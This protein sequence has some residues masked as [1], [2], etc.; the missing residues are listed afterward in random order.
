ME[1]FTATTATTVAKIFMKSAGSSF[2]SYL[3]KA[4]LAENPDFKILVMQAKQVAVTEFQKDFKGVEIF[5]DEQFEQALDA[6]ATSAVASINNEPFNIIENLNNYFIKEALLYHENEQTKDVYCKSFC[7]KFSI[8][9]YAQLLSSKKYASLLNAKEVIAESQFRHNTTNTLEQVQKQLKELKDGQEK[10]TENMISSNRSICLS[11]SDDEESLQLSKETDNEIVELFNQIEQLIKDDGPYTEQIRLS[12]KVIIKIPPNN[13]SLYTKAVNTL[14]GAYLRGN[15]T[16]YE[17]GLNE[18][19]KY[20]QYFNTYSKVI[21]AALLNN[22]KRWT[23][24]LEI[25]SS[26]SKSDVLTF[27]RKQQNSYRVVYS[28][29]KYHLNDLRDAHES[30]E[31]CP[32]K[33]DPEYIYVSFMLSSAD[34]SLSL[35][36]KATDIFSN[37][38]S[39]IRLIHGALCY[40]I[41]RFIKLQKEYGN[42]LEAMEQLAPHLDLAF[43]RTK[44]TIERF[45][46]A[47]NDVVKDLV[48]NIPLLARLSGRS[49]D[50]IDIIQYALDLSYEE[51]IFLQNS[52]VCLLE[53]GKMELALYCMEQIRVEQMIQNDNGIEIY[54]LLLRKM[55]KSEKLTSILEEIANLQISEEK[56]WQPLLSVAMEIGGETFYKLA[57]EA[58]KKFPDEGWAILAVAESYIQQ[59]NFDK[60][61]ALLKSSLEQKGIKLFAMIRLAK[62]YASTL[63]RPEEA[64]TYY[65]EVI[66]INTPINEKIEYVHCLFDIKK[67]GDVI[68]KVDEYDPTGKVA[69]LQKLKSF[70]CYELGMIKEAKKIIYEVCKIETDDY[71]AHYNHAIFC[72]ELGMTDELIEALLNTIRIRPNDFQSHLTLSQAFLSQGKLIEA[73]KHAEFS[74][75][76][77]FKN[78]IAHFNF[79]N[80]HR[81][82]SQAL[83]EDTYINSK[84]LED[85]HR[86]ALNNYTTR[87]PKSKIMYSVQIPNDDDGKPS[88]QFIKEMLSQ[89]SEQESTIFNLYKDNAAPLSFLKTGLKMDFYELWCALLGNVDGVNLVLSRSST[90]QL[91]TDVSKIR[92]SKNILLDGMSLIVLQSSN[93]LLN[94]KHL[95]KKIL[96]C[97][98]TAKEFMA[99]KLRLQST[100]DGYMSVGMQEGKMVREDITSDKISHAI[101][102]IDN[103]SKFINE[104]CEVIS[105]PEKNKTNRKPDQVSKLLD[106]EYKELWNLSSSLEACSS[107]WADGNIIELARTQ[108]KE[109]STIQ[110]LIVYLLQ[111]KIITYEQYA[112]YIGDMIIAN[113]Q[114]ITFTSSESTIFLLNNQSVRGEFYFSKIIKG[115]YF[116]NFE[117]RLQFISDIIINALKNNFKPAWLVTLI[118]NDLLGANVDE[119]HKIFFGVILYSIAIEQNINSKEVDDFIKDLQISDSSGQIISAEELK[120]YVHHAFLQKKQEE[121]ESYKQKLGLTPPPETSKK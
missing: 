105:L 118:R 67:N 107:I 18:I 86:D 72:R 11:L 104:N 119:G 64:I 2:G 97:A 89:R 17:E 36:Q 57:S 22:S 51:S 16:S 29:I 87:F 43:V 62:L 98:E 12:N 26:I 95:N 9:L 14:L 120:A 53:C 38:D 39:N 45:K 6:I 8:Q 34:D 60:G 103:I 63:N 113:Y 84:E 20:Q 44:E 83:P 91:L 109:I 66:K 28:L 56:K 23:D 108:G 85:L 100:A 76:G 93:Q 58:E 115:P 61:I 106:H 75:L 31:Q 55:G 41:D 52:A 70:A 96:I 48:L 47:N 27:S 10:I 112:E 42:A 80:I 82:A 59:H 90:N 88:L 68:K 111:E 101:Q 102:F 81:R 116:N 54:I 21:V 114:G 69:T 110:A 65:E 35:L 71:N 92:N 7:E 3:A 77:D 79:I 117:H 24:G 121:L 49:K 32:D 73:V 25:I 13:R 99:I 74:L 50:A 15:P 19:T 33:N 1:I 94:L 5:S 4:F 40:T 78:E 37:K 30:L 46:V